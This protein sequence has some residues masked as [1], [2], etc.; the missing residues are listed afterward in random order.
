M[1]RW[2]FAFGVP[3]GTKSGGTLLQN[4]FLRTL[5]AV[6]DDVTTRSHEVSSFVQGLTFF[7][8]IQELAG[9]GA[10]CGGEEEDAEEH[11][12]AS[13]GMGGSSADGSSADGSTD[14]DDDNGTDDPLYLGI[15]K[16]KEVIVVVDGCLLYTSPSPRDGLLSRMPSS[17]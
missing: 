4:L 9:D 12:S 15:T 6:G 3:L 7:E 11:S 17:A 10:R 8:M 1:A 13:S 5:E 16:A 2:H 14:E